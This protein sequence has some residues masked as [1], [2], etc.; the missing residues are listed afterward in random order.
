M[1]IYNSASTRPSCPE[2]VHVYNFLLEQNA[3]E[4]FEEFKPL[5]LEKGL[6]CLLPTKRR[7]FRNFLSHS[8][9]YS[10]SNEWHALLFLCLLVNNETYTPNDFLKRYYEAISY[11][12]GYY[13]ILDCLQPSI[14]LINKIVQTSKFFDHSIHF[15]ILYEFPENGTFRV[16]WESIDFEEDAVLIYHPN[17][18]N[19]DYYVPY[20]YDLILSDIPAG[21]VPE[22]I[23]EKWTFSADCI[24]GHVISVRTQQDYSSVIKTLTSP[25]SP[26][27][28]EQEEPDIYSETA[29]NRC[30]DEYRSGKT[31]SHSHPIK[32]KDSSYLKY[33]ASSQY[34]AVP[35]RFCYERKINASATHLQYLEDAILFTTRVNENKAIV[36]YENSN[37]SR[38]TYIFAVKHSRLV[39]TSEQ[40]LDFFSS[41]TPNKREK[42]FNGVIDF[43]KMGVTRFVRIT[44]DYYNQWK[45]DL[46]YYSNYLLND[47][48]S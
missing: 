39:D 8:S 21:M 31:Y 15:E 35:F 37:S 12:E 1:G 28:E 18:R 25:P 30:I 9:F 44:H 24:N 11:D 27:I 29:I 43:E 40:I 16:P 42:I 36:V 14:K 23:K 34:G 26:Q 10:K 20:K 3:I 45:R 7:N 32:I 17:H 48:S 41:S 6:V 2:E 38:S 13:K 46:V 22:D 5:R 33:L 4:Y 19:D 47:C